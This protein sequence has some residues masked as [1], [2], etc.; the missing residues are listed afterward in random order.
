VVCD[1]QQACSMDSCDPLTG[2]CQFDITTCPC[3]TAQDCD[4]GNACNGVEDCDPN[5]GCLAGTPMDCDDGNSCTDDSC[6]SSTNECSNISNASLTGCAP[7]PAITPPTGPA[8]NNLEG[9]GCSLHFAAP[10][11]HLVFGPLLLGLGSMVLLRGQ[12]KK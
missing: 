1:D 11:S 4:D 2:Q 10:A 9:S 8:G 5:T 12:R 7:D 3:S 6:D